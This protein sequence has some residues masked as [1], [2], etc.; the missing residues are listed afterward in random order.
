MPVLPG[1]SSMLPM[2]YH[3][4]DTTTGDRLSILAIIR[5]P[6]SRVFS[7]IELWQ[8]ASRKTGKTNKTDKRRCIYLIP[9]NKSDRIAHYTISVFPLPTC[10]VIYP[11]VSDSSTSKGLL[12]RLGDRLKSTRQVLGSGLLGQARPSEEEL[13]DLETA[14]LQADAGVAVTQALIAEVESARNQTANDALRSAMLQILRPCQKALSV[15]IQQKPYVIMMVG[16][17]GVG[18]TTT[19]G[20]LAQRFHQQGLKTML[21]GA[22]TFRAAAIEQL[23]SWGDRLGIPVIAQHTGA[24]AA[25]VAH[26]AVE[27]ARARGFDVLIID[28]AGRQATHEGLMQELAKIKRVIQKIIPE[29]PQEILQVVD[30]GTGQNALSQ[31][32]QFNA[33]VGVTGIAVT[34]LDGTSKGGTVLALCKEFGIPIR[35]IGIGEAAED[36]TDFSADAFV[37]AILPEPDQ[38]EIS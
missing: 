11:N 19:S 1:C 10:E 7:S 27:S 26:D 5:I 22:D 34:K 17:N 18:K 23:Q 21:A 2:R 14:L 28:T 15:D 30:G 12:G 13:E 8:A 20:K 25:A 31:L 3:I 33:V 6:L 16:V 29:A 24:D 37:E 32:R 4:C 35:Y 9:I 38:T 36:L